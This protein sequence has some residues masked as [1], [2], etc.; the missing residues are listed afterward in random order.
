MKNL[1]AMVKVQQS[2]IAFIEAHPIADPASTKKAY[3]DVKLPKLY[4]WGYRAFLD[5]LPYKEAKRIVKDWDTWTRERNSDVRPLWMR[6]YRALPFFLYR[7]AY[8]CFL[9]FRK[10]YA[11]IKK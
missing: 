2:T 3:F 4:A 7:F 9:K 5:S 1:K 11:K 8:K 6:L 10:L